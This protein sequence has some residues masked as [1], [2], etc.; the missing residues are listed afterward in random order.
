MRDDRKP[1]AKFVSQ[2]T[3]RVG[4]D[5]GEIFSTVLGSCVAACLHDPVRRIGGMNHFLLPARTGGGSPDL[6]YG[7]NLMERMINDLLKRG[8]RKQDLVA[9]VFGGANVAVGGSTVGARNSSF[10]R[11]FLEREGIECVARS[12]GGD[13]ARR[14]RFWPHTGRAS[15][16]LLNP[17][18]VQTELATPVQPVPAASPGQDTEIWD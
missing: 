16:L 18:E 15:Q 13:R 7:V 5:P 14:I 1:A 8:S 9:K 6:R 10:V 2:S 12:L 17:S 11:S 3:Y 4:D